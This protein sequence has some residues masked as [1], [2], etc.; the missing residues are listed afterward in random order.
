MYLMK[1]QH[2]LD[3]PGYTKIYADAKRPTAHGT[4]AATRMLALLSAMF[5]HAKLPNPTEGV[6]RFKEQK[7][8]RFLCAD[9]ARLFAALAAEPNL[10]IR[11]FVLV[12]IITGA[13]PTSK[14]CVGLT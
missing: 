8:E 7:R 3:L 2:L 6:K 4:Y 13:L 1:S 11:D 10:T 5:N 14:R 9:D 12:S